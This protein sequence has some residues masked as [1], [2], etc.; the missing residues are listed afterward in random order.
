MDVKRQKRNYAIEIKALKDRAEFHTRYE[1]FGRLNELRELADSI[2]EDNIRDQEFIKLFPVRL[3]AILESYFRSIVKSLIDHGEPFLKNVPKLNQP[4]DGKISIELLLSMNESEFTLGE[5][6]AHVL[7]CSK[8]NEMISVLNTLTE[9]DILNELK[10]YMPT[11]I[12]EHNI[13]IADAYITNEPLIKSDIFEIYR[14]RNIFCHELGATEKVKPAKIRVLV[15][16][17]SFFINHLDN[18][19]ENL[20][21]P[22]APETNADIQTTL[23]A[24]LQNS[25]EVLRQ[26]I[27]QI[28]IALEAI[29]SPNFEINLFRKIQ[30][31]WE[32]FR[33]ANCEMAAHIYEGGTMYPQL[34]ISEKIEQTEKRIKELNQL[35]RHELEEFGKSQQ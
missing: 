27:S 14:L 4:N 23:L 29:D 7:P 17:M 15:A 26:L 9:Q 20:I 12:Y 30:Q 31:H 5:L 16:S 21:H 25:E 33:D 22:N 35:F 24:K 8:F 1:M 18:Y 11:T 19:I 32:A 3:V 34:F 13:T 6:I 2:Q 10:Q 28:Q